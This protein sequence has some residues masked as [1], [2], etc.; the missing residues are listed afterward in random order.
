MPI[1]QTLTWEDFCKKV[2]CEDLTLQIYPKTTADQVILNED[3]GLTLSQW[4]GTSPLTGTLLSW[5]MVNYPMNGGG[6]GSY[7]L[8]VATSTVLGG[9]KIGSGLA[10][11]DGVVSTDLSASSIINSGIKIG[12]IKAG[13]STVDLYTPN[14]KLIAQEASSGTT[15]V[16]QQGETIQNTFTIPDND[17]TYTF[18]ASGST[19]NITN[20]R[21][22]VTQAISL[23]P[24]EVSYRLT[25]K[26]NA[27]DTE[28]SLIKDNITIDNVVVPNNTYTFAS[29]GSVFKVTDNLAQTTQSFTFN[30]AIPEIS[31]SVDTRATDYRFQLKVGNNVASDV[32]APKALD[33]IIGMGAWHDITNHTIGFSTKDFSLNTEFPT[34][35][36]AADYCF[37]LQCYSPLLQWEYASTT[38]PDGY[39]DSIVFLPQLT[40]SRGL[41]WFKIDGTIDQ[42]GAPVN[43]TSIGHI[44][45][46]TAATKIPTIT[47]NVI[48]LPALTYD[49][50]G[51]I[52]AAVDTT[53]TIPSTTMVSANT[54]TV[55]RVTTI[56]APTTDAKTTYIYTADT[57]K[58]RSITLPGE[59]G[60]NYVSINNGVTTGTDNIIAFNTM[61]D[62]NNN[63]IDVI[64]IPIGSPASISIERFII[65]TVNNTY[66]YFIN[67]QLLKIGVATE[68]TTTGTGTDTGTT[69]TG[70]VTPTTG[71][72]GGNIG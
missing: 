32:T 1:K 45:T 40:T 4:I 36:T 41:A 28:L 11:D 43:G 38:G 13:T 9:I 3:T 8:P 34:G 33:Y 63:W 61:Q 29:T 22:D 15:L 60:K 68:T 65:D 35:K 51:H 67:A 30:T 17:T 64:R 39:F 27:N 6:G 66:A 44:N 55:A 49:E 52:T 23:V 2:S 20:N 37:K 26:V 42:S 53:I 47:D 10:I 16:L 24:S 70:T 57:T 56:T 71:T 12:S 48:T 18:A 62:T 69:D 54:I 31:L 5:L 58:A 72:D 7:T 59:V 46:V 14:V 50:Y 21:T 25:G 19:L